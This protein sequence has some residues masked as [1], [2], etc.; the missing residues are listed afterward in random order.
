MDASPVEIRLTSLEDHIDTYVPEVTV[1]ESLKLD[2]SVA[3]FHLA[4]VVADMERALE[5]PATIT[6]AAVQRWADKLRT[7]TDR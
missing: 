5:N 4:A 6:P 7:R 3:R 1:A 2:I